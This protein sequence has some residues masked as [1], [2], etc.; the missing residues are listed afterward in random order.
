MGGDFSGMPVLTLAFAFQP[1]WRF[2]IRDALRSVGGGTPAVTHPA[3]TPLHPGATLL[4]VRDLQVA[5]GPARQP[6]PVVRG[7]SL[8]V[9]TG[10]IFE[11]LGEV[12]VEQERRTVHAINGLLPAGARVTGGSVKF[13]GEELIGTSRRR[14]SQLR[15]DSIGMVF[16]DS[17]TSLNPIMRIGLQVAEPLLLHGKANARQARQLVG[18]RLRAMGMPDVHEALRR[19]HTS[20]P[21][22][23]ASARPSRRR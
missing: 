7:V 22:G 13:N 2:T 11:L 19:Y 20:S 4:D 23:C 15:G 16:Q 14:L 6:L 3:V 17:L 1:D 18:E 9:D 5:V 12:R 8:Q 21:A 10:E